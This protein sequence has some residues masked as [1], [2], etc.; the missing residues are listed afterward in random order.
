MIHYSLMPS[1][2]GPLLLV[3]EGGALTGVYMEEHKRGRQ[4]DPAWMRDD[5]SLGFARVQLEEYFAGVRRKFDLPLAARGTPFQKKVWAALGEIPY[6]T[7]ATYREL[8]RAIGMPGSSRA[9]GAANARN[10]ISIIVPCH[11]VI[12]TDGSLT[13]YA[14]GAERKRWLL[15]FEKHAQAAFGWMAASPAAPNR[16][17]TRRHRPGGIAPPGPVDANLLPVGTRRRT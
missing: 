3:A 2:I 6:G 12:G 5:A 11:R 8:A 15:E 10:P 16:R 9:V 1:P 13:G 17:G 14:G 4:V 7:T